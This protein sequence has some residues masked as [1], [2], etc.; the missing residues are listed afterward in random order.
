MWYKSA[1]SNNVKPSAIDTTSSRVSVFLRKNFVSIAEKT[2]G[3]Q[4]TPEHWEYEECKMSV[5]EYERYIE[6][7][8]KIDYIA[9]VAGV[10]FPTEA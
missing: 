2:E 6:Q 5:D 4:T 8:S 3:N 7:Q 1:N 9:L 10:D